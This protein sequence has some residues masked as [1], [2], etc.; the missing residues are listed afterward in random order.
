MHNCKNVKIYYD[1]DQRLFGVSTLQDALFILEP[2]YKTNALGDFIKNLFEDNPTTEGYAVVNHSADAVKGYRLVEVT[3]EP[4][5]AF[6]F[7]P[8]Q[9]DIEREGAF[10]DIKGV[11]VKSPVYNRFVPMPNASLALALRTAMDIVDEQ[12]SA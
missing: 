2:S 1:T 12:E 10:K 9:P 11:L 4:D 7:M 5:G 6:A 3:K 8:M